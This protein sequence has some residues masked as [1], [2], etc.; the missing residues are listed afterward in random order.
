MKGCFKAKFDHAL[1]DA[2]IQAIKIT[3]SVG[4]V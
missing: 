3:Q 4:D 2:K 1:K